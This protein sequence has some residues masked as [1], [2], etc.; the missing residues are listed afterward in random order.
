LAGEEQSDETDIG[1]SGL[2]GLC[3]VLYGRVAV[4]VNHTSS[5]V[6]SAVIKL[7]Q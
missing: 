3:S 5:V 2:L 6:F 7:M 4:S 1:W